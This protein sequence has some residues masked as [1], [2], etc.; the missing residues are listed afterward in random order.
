M[1]KNRNHQLKS[2]H[3]QKW[4]HLSANSV[5]GSRNHGVQS[6]KTRPNLSCPLQIQSGGPNWEISWLSS[7]LVS[8]S[9]W[10]KRRQTLSCSNSEPIRRKY[11]TYS[12]EICMMRASARSLDSK[13]SKFW[14]IRQRRRRRKKVRLGNR[15]E[16]KY[17]RRAVPLKH[18]SIWAAR[19]TLW[20]SFRSLCGRS[21]SRRWADL[22]Q[23][24]SNIFAHLRAK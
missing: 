23:A 22:S 18:N 3:H 19:R 9:D 12:Q 15:K 8:L 2:K 20:A 14:A 6:T 4:L 5:E 11:F 1:I 24:A 16:T 17:K 7:G 10:I 21:R 13:L